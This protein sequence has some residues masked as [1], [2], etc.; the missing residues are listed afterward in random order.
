LA[1]PALWETSDGAR[2][3]PGDRW[4]NSIGRLTQAGDPRRPRMALATCY[5]DVVFPWEV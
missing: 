5:E 2:E 4:C 3:M 1:H